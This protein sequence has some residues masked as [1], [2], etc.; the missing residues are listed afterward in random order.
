MKRI[1][2]LLLFFI[3]CSCGVK[4]TKS[5]VSSGDYDGAIR[6]AVSD[7]RTG[8]EKKGKQDYVYL[9]EEAFAKAKERDV[10]V[11][12]DLAKEGNPR[13]LERIYTTYLQLRD[14]QELIRPLLPL[15]LIKEGRAAIFPFDDYS[16]QIISS[17]NALA[18]YLYTNARGLLGTSDKMNFRRAYDDLAYLDGISPNYKDVRKLME[19]AKSKGLDYVSVYAKNETDIAIPY[20]LENDLLDFNTYGLNDKWTVYHSNKQ[21]GINY[22]YG[23]IVNFREINISPEQVKEKEFDRER[24]VKVGTKKLLDAQN[25]EVKDDKGNVI[26]VDDMITA[27]ASVYE[28]RQFKSVQ[29]TA[30]VD[31]IDFKTNQLLQSFPLSSEFVFENIYSKCRGD[32]RALD[33]DYYVFLNQRIMPFPSNEQMVYD[34]GENLKAKIKDILSKNRIRN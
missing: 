31:Y 22:N 14:R 21:K 24:Q 18:A 17:K 30:K 19:N 4:Q 6:N 10:R 15:R 16:D 25:R 33:Q 2:L 1:T 27:R 12:K 5:M 13:D 34:S 26:M 23:L 20:R 28:V 29:V 9:L 11:A 3:V 7:L 32:K 8:K